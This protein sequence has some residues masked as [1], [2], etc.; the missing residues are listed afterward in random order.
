VP[1]LKFVTLAIL[2]LL[3]FNAQKLRG[4]VTLAT[5]PFRIFL[6]LS[7]LSIGALTPNSKFV[8]L[9][10]ILAFNAQSLWGYVTPV[11]PFDISGLAA[12]KRRRMNYEPL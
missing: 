9:T 6:G 11:T 1:N 12:P 5:P 7:G 8:A 3:P 2:E 10:E 4:R